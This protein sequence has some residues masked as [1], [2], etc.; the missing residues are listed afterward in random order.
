V[1][2][3]AGVVERANP[4]EIDMKIRKDLVPGLIAATAI[5]FAVMPDAFAE[6]PAKAPTKGVKATDKQRVFSSP[7]EA[8]EALVQAVKAKSVD[9]LL[10]VVGP[11][12]RSWLFTGDRVSD[13]NDWRRF[14]QAYDEKHAIQNEGDKATLL[15]GN[16]EWPFPAPIVKRGS[17]WVFDADAGREE[18]TNRRVGRNELDAIQTLLAVV[19]AQREYAAT[20]ADGNGFADYA[21]HFR[22]TPGKKDGLYWPEV[23][24]QPESPLGP[25]VAVA[26]REGYGKDKPQAYH[27]Y[28]FKMLY[29]QGKDA[30]GGA[31]DYMVGDKLLGG[32]AVVAWPANYGVSGVMT[33]LV[34]HEGVVFEKDLGK[35][36]AS[37]AGAM[38]RY[39]PD[40][41]WRKSQ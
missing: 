30:A 14:V 16:D 18:I 12:S 38:T 32:F 11:A 1:G 36:T 27:G 31:Y 28:H 10:M 22:S 34:N 25:L 4:E 17:Q 3:A 20:D 40:A 35:P 39:N 21:K 29:A 7:D 15:V 24:G 5:T 13:A 19:D 8:A 9:S 26:S 41:T 37:I 23:A 6:T 33:F 2:V